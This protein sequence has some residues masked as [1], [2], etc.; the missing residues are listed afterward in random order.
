M[1]TRADGTI[2]AKTLAELSITEIK[3]RPVGRFGAMRRD[4]TRE[5][6]GK[7]LIGL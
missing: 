4:F 2:T 5:T 3:L 1:A 7:G 6:W